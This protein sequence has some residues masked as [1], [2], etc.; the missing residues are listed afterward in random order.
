[1]FKT[2][3]GLIEERD[4]STGL[5]SPLRVFYVVASPEAGPNSHLLKV[6]LE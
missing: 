5:A 3:P 4:Q 6:V 1:M 2:R